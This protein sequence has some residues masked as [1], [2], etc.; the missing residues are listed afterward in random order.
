MKYIQIEKATI[1]DHDYVMLVNILLTDL[2]QN[3]VAYIAGHAIKMTERIIKLKMMKKLK[4]YC[5]NFVGLNY[6]NKC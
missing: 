3:V 5:E 4:V 6:R 2:I 1:Y